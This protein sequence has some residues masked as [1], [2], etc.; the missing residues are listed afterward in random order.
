VKIYQLEEISTL[1]SENGFDIIRAGTRRSLKRILFLP[2][3]ALISMI[4]HGYIGGSVLWDI[5]G[6]ANYLIARKK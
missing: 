3:Y 4:S 1:L 5:F 2:M 6:F